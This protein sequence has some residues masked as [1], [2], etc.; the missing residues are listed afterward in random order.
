MNW[1]K[2]KRQSFSLIDPL[3]K[4][5][6]AGM[7]GSL[8]ILILANLFLFW[9][10]GNIKAKLK[11]EKVRYAECIEVNSRTNTRLADIIKEHNAIKGLLE[12]SQ[13][14]AKETALERQIER[15]DAE[16][17]LNEERA[18][19]A[20]IYEEVPEC[21]AWH[22]MPICDPIFERMQDRANQRG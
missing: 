19:N 5:A 1:L 11:V 6:I 16:R 10:S 17:K 18:K 20:E 4:Y 13:K 3:F 14:T 7:L 21:Q 15:E 22:D 9:R 2:S 8:A 12:A